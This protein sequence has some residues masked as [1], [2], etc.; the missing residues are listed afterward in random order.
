MIVC[1]GRIEKQHAEAVKQFMKWL[2]Y[3]EYKENFVLVYNKS[4]LLSPQ[5]K[6]ENLSAMCS[7]F[8]V[9]MNNQRV[10]NTKTGKN[11]AIKMNLAL[12]FPPNADYETVKNDPLALWN[13]VGVPQNKRIPVE[14]STCTIL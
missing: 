8:E 10:M 5:E 4:D 9:P 6:I 1:S 14:K 7:K 12:G 11:F 13:A 2:S 3:K